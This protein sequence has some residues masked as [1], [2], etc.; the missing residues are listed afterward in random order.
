VVFA[1]ETGRLVAVGI[2]VLLL[3]VLVLAFVAYTRRARRDDGLRRA[4]ERAGDETKVCPDCASEIAREARAC[5]H[6]GYKFA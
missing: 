6:C 1:L 3:L 4:A 2:A 5:Q